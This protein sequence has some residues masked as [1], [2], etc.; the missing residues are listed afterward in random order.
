M[1]LIGCGSVSFQGS[2]A[3][4]IASALQGRVGRLTQYARG[5][6]WVS[7]PFLQNKISEF[8]SRSVEG[9]ENCMS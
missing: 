2:S 4:Q 8:L 7:P 3:L 1:S 5:K 6:T 9:D